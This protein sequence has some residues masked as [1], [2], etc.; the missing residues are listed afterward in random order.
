MNPAQLLAMLNAAETFAD[1]I[2]V[3]ISEDE[4]FTDEEKAKVLARVNQQ[5]DTYDDAIAAAKARLAAGGNG[6]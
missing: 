2:I 1:M 5:H 3:A 6:S 4:R